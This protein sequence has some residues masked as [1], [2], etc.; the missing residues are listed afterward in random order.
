M[1]EESVPDSE[2]AGQPG[3]LSVATTTTTDGIRVLHPTGEIDHHTCGQLRQALDTLP[4]DRPRVVIDL[5]GVP[6]MDSSGINILI[7]AYKNVTAAD[8]WIRIA[9]PTT[10]VLRVLQLVRVDGLITC[11]PDLS[12]ALAP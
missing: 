9:A 7:A 6:F 1:A 4:A 3:G 5:S 12:Q 2:R 10:P 8:G 11:Y